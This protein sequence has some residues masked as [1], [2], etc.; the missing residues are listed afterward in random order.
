MRWRVL[1]A[2]GI[3]AGILAAGL[4]FRIH[5]TNCCNEIEALLLQSEPSLQQLEQALNLWEKEVPL[6]SALLHHD[7]MERVGQEL[8][9]GLG[10]LKSGDLPG[11][12]GQI[13]IILYLLDDIRDYDDISFKT[14]F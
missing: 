9:R 14:L 11:C 5:V 2:F 6:L 3:I 8:S 1:I 12:K 13:D 4:N 7:L 10:L